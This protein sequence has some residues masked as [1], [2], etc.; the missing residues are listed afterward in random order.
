MSFNKKIIQITVRLGSGQ[1]GNQVG[2]DVAVLN[3]YRTIVNM[4]AYFGQTQGTVQCRIYGLSMDL[5]TKLT[6]IGPIAY[7]IR[8]KNSISISVGDSLST[9][10]QIFLG[11]IQTSWADFQEAPNVSLNIVAFSMLWA[12]VL[13]ISPAS[14]SG[15]QSINTIIRQLVNNINSAAPEQNLIFINQ[16]V[17]TQLK[18]MYLPGSGFDQI[19]AVIKAAQCNYK[20]EQNVLTI[21][22]IGQPTADSPIVLSPQSDPGIVGYPTFSSDGVV[23]KSTF[24]PITQGQQITIQNSIIPQA[25]NTWIANNIIHNLESERPGGAWFTQFTG[26]RFLQ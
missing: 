26:T 21:W 22:P 16:G 24:L 5:M 25:N 4:S 3:G 9:L 19:K 2:S 13:P 1:F 15:Y 12:S 11:T 17:N 10:T 23:I 20:I 8:G 6:T 18:D 7:Q 14:F